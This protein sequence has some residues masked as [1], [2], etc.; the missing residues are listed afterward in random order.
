MTDSK[1]SQ[2]HT[3]KADALGLLGTV[4]LTAAYMAP[5]A[6]VI[7]LF[8]PVYIIAGTKSA[9]V[10]LIGLIIT[11][12]SGISFGML[13]KELPAAGGVASWARTT[14]GMHIGRWV[15]ITTALFYILHF[16][17]KH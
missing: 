4:S 5:A 10:M 9:F 6:A 16:L 13:A 11:L 7:A 14:L 3:L 8:A 12:P 2:S 1:S 15:G 17:K